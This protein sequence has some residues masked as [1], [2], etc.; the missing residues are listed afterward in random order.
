MI[1]DSLLTGDKQPAAQISRGLESIF[2]VVVPP[3]PF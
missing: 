2:M 1:T 3:M